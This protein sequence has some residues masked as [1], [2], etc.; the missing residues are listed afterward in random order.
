M[1]PL[2]GQERRLPALV[3]TISREGLVSLIALATLLHAGD[4]AAE[5]TGSV[6]EPSFAE[7]SR[8]GIALKLANTLEFGL[9]R[10][11]LTQGNPS[12]SGGFVKGT[13]QRNPDVVWL[14][15][16]SAQH[17]FND[18][19]VY[20]SLGATRV[21]NQD[22]YGAL[23][24]A[25]SSGGFFLPRFRVDAFLSRKWLE[26]RNLVTTAGLSGIRAKD[27]HRDLNLFLGSS[28]YFDTPWIVEG[29]FHF[30]RSDPGG[31]TANNAYAA[32]TRGRAGDY[33]LTLRHSA[34]REAYQ[35]IGPEATI[36][37]F[38]S[39]SSSLVYRKWLSPRI[40]FNL[41]AEHYSNPFYRRNSV[42]VSTF[43]D[44]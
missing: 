4:V 8:I 33:Y 13:W 19:G 10:S 26:Q 31:V 1:R 36:S 30:N 32:V 12:W 43:Q 20:L 5:A 40:G 27:E 15:E 41:R 17:R 28:Y 23:F 3:S 14:G 39:R 42:E 11:D 6:S 29:G 18:R 21:F 2:N 37:D 16:V 35:L 25:T 22:W 24:A 9:H 38:S 7:E 44:F 34:G